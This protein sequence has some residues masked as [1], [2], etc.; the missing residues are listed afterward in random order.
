MI[1]FNSPVTVVFVPWHSAILKLNKYAPTH[2]SVEDMS[3]NILNIKQELANNYTIDMGGIFHIEM[4][5]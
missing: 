3:A 4:E 1:R 2:F 5:E